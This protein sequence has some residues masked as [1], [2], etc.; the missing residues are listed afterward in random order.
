MIKFR[1]KYWILHVLDEIPL[2]SC[3]GFYYEDV[4]YVLLMHVGS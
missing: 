4:L 1:A 2:F 3:L